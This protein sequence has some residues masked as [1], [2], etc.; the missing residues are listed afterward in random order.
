MDAVATYGVA[1]HIRAAGGRTGKVSA[2]AARRADLKWLDQLLAWQP[3]SASRDF[4]D[5]LRGDLDGAGFLV[6]AADG[7][8]VP[9]P[10]GSTG[11]D[12]AYVTSPQTANEVT[13]VLVDG[14]RVPVER[15]LV[16]GQ[17]VELIHGPPADPPES[18]LR[19]AHS[20]QAR[21]HLQQWFASRADEE[22]E[23]AAEEAAASGRGTLATALLERG[24]AL[25]DLEADGTAHSEC[26]K[27]G[28]GDLDALYAALGQDSVAIDNLVAA[29]LTRPS[30]P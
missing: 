2:E 18:W 19:A 23:L 21:A 15:P 29:L 27:L 8:P 28:Y 13:G 4:L 24:I 1:A 17:V 6:F 7:S 12:F 30:S 11:V 20:G 26:R 3:L 10:S 5:S 14:I 16:H 22:A 9:L 25:I